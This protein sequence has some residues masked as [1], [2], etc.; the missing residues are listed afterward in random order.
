[1]DRVKSSGEGAVVAGALSIL[2]RTPVQV[3]QK[4]L[5]LFAGRATAVVT[6]IAAPRD[7]VALAGVPLAGFTAWVPSTGPVGI[8]LAICSTPVSCCS[9]LRSMRR[10]CRS[11]SN[12]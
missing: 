6:N 10:F 12:C 5:D 8:G 9:A 3:E 4:W 11:P 7:P 2:G 1:M